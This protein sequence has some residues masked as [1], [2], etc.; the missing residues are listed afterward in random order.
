M[1]L[2]TLLLAA[3]PYLAIFPLLIRYKFPAP[4][5]CGSGA[6]EQMDQE[7]NHR[8]HKQDMNQSACDV[9]HQKSPGP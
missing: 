3:L 4:R 2:F 6:S 9:E 8:Q 1:A 5:L 7:G